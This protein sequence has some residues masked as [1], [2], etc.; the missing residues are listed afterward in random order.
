MQIDRVSLSNFRNYASAAFFFDEPRTLIA[1]PNGSG[2]STIL[3][4]IAWVL[5][6]ECRGVDGR[7]GGQKDLIRDGA[8]SAT[9]TLVLDGKTYQRSVDAA[10]AKATVKPDV[11]LERLGVSKAMLLACLDGQSFF[12]LDHKAARDLLLDL[13]GVV[14]RP[15]DAPDLNLPAPISLGDLDFRY[16]QAFDD[17]AAA[18]KT[19]AALQ[20]PEPPKV[21]DIDAGAVGDV[22][23][24]RAARESIK[25]QARDARD[26]WQTAKSRADSIAQEVKAARAALDQVADWQGKVDAQRAMLA[27]T[28]AAGQA[29]IQPVLAEG[30]RSMADIQRELSDL[31]GMLGR[32]EHHQPAGGCVLNASIPCLTPAKDFAKQV[33]GITRSI[34]SLRAAMKDAEQVTKDQA[35][36]DAAVRENQRSVAYHKGQI[37]K[38]TALIAEADKGKARIA[39]LE[40]EAKALIRDL[41]KLEAVAGDTMKADAA[42]ERRLL[43]ATAYQEAVRGHAAALARRDQAEA[44]VARLD[45]LV[46]LLGPKG[47]RMTVLARSIGEFQTSINEAMAGF[48]FRMTFQD[49]PWAITVNG[50]PYT[51]LSA[52]EKLLVGSAF[53]QALALASGLE[54]AAIDAS[55]VVVGTMRDALTDLVLQSP[56]KQVLIAMAKDDDD[57]L[58]TDIDG[59]QIIQPHKD[60]ALSATT[61]EFAGLEPNR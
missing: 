9:V 40:K 61:K 29:I 46:D 30:A 25:D 5:T 47:I 4:A 11:I 15:E 59:L 44:T 10:G 1:G 54:F 31:Q 33:D 2:K 22:A 21:A 43:A 8:E 50:R 42:A 18:K 12:D 60:P 16:K 19:L 35:A 3:D 26:A 32:V 14:V 58:P 41:P 20:V 13:L 6:G 37:D 48:G 36:Y 27:D 53:Q 24:I 57:P 49:D 28:E 23:A 52:G 7:G 55:E 45:A 34:R 51:L 56:V 39:A 17:R 38:L